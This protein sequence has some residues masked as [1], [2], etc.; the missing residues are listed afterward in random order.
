MEIIDTDTSIDGEEKKAIV[1]YTI[2][3]I[4]EQRKKH[5]PEKKELLENMEELLH[6]A[7]DTLP[8]I[9]DLVVAGSRGELDLK[10]RKQ[11]IGLFI[12]I[13]GSCLVACGNAASRK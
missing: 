13:F 8:D 11:R 5:N 1:I 7:E 12:R 4:I 6:F 2:K 3:E 10:T 9:I